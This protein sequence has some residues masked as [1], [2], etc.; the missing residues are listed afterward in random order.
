LHHKN[1]I[2]QLPEIRS[3]YWQAREE[4][5]NSKFETLEPVISVGSSVDETLMEHVLATT[6]DSIDSISK[7]KI[8]WSV[9][10]RL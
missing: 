5:S 3:P 10:M 4:N 6:R 1:R 8:T 2:L 7:K 9:L